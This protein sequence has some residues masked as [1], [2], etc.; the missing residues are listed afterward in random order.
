ML[1][2]ILLVVH[3]GR[4][5]RAAALAAELGARHSARVE[6]VC[7]APLPELS[8]E[9]CFVLG[10]AAINA[11]A[12]RMQDETGL[13]ADQALGPVRDAMDLA[14]CA[15]DWTVADAGEPPAQTALRAR[16]VDL[17][18]LARPHANQGAGL[19]FAE[20][21]IRHGGAPCLLIPDTWDSDRPLD[22]AVLAWN[23]SRQAK[24]AMDDALPLLRDAKRVSLLSVGPG[25]GLAREHD[26][27]IA[28]LRRQ[29]VDADLAVVPEG[30]GGRG[31][32]LLTWC[33]RNAADLLVMGAF[34]RT[35][36]SERWF[37]GATWIAL[38]TAQLP[39]LM[40]C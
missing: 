23:G 11:V 18:L 28:H 27:L 10:H 9:D 2:D 16:L 14:G 15:F 40:S 38:T 35:P 5:S 21:L 22:H 1:S 6:G 37:Q 31:P 24:R 12:D 30:H 20:T 25:E 36:R 26:G 39:V 7:L 34:G 19:V 13:L 29:G 3:P 32:A 33:G 8:P 4:D 17:V